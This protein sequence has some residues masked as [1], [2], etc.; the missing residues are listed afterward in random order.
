M[1]FASSSTGNRPFVI[2]EEVGYNFKKTFRKP[3]ENFTGNKGNGNLCNRCGG[4]PHSS[5]PCPVLNKKGNTCE[6]MKRWGTFQ[7]CAEVK[8]SLSQV[9]LTSTTTS[10]RKRVSCLVRKGDGNV[11]YTGKCV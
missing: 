4:K 9:S 1:A 6:K 2:K 7:K 11:L 5:K 3:S 8:P 10:A